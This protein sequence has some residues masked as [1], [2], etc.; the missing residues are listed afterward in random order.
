MTPKFQD[1]ESGFTREKMGKSAE[2][3]CFVDEESGLGCVL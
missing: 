1:W 3:A 2:E